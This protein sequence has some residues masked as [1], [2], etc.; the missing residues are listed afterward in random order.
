MAVIISM[1]LQEGQTGW[2]V[3]VLGVRTVRLIGPYRGAFWMFYDFRRIVEEV[4]WIL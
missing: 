2:W 4:R 3:L 1:L